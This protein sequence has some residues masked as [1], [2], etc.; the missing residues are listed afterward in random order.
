LPVCLTD[1]DYA[2]AKAGNQ[3][4]IRRNEQE[5]K[6]RN[7]MH[8]R[9]Y[10]LRL[11]KP[12]AVNVTASSDFI[13]GDPIDLKQIKKTRYKLVLCIF[14]DSLTWALLKDNSLKE[15]LP[16]IDKFFS[17][18]TIFDNCYTWGTWTLTSASCIVSG[19]SIKNHGIFH[20]NKN[21][22]LGSSY[23][24]MSEYFQDAGYL[25]FQSC[26]NW[27]KTPAYGY[28]RGYDRTVFK[29]EMGIEETI[30]PLMDHLR[31][32]PERSHFAW[33]S[34]N[35]AHHAMRLTSEISV[36]TRLDIA[37]HD[38]LEKTAKKKRDPIISDP[39]R[40]ARYAEEMKMIDF[41]LGLLFSYVTD[42]YTDDEILVSL[43]SDHGVNYL[44]GE[45]VSLTEGETHTAMM[46]RGGGVPAARADE[47]VQNIDLLPSMLHFSNIAAPASLDGKLPPA[48][49]G[50]DERSFVM[51]EMIYPGNPYQASV[52]S[53]EFDL[54]FT[55]EHATGD[56]GKTDLGNFEFKLFKGGDYSNDVNE[57]HVDTGK[58]LLNYLLAY[59]DKPG[60]E[61]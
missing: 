7:L 17:K 44:T 48:L 6:L 39:P 34:L 22:P 58:E 49:G 11:D 15:T 56:N 25:T 45:A 38:Y 18:G 1:S 36:Q 61:R 16:N 47:L 13:V 4:S 9:F 2:K 24:I 41:N 3:I 42:H 26:G 14:V 12:G 40:S 10:Y 54:Q 53:K 55:S 23:K 33:I 46:I 32:F 31:A 8:D 19:L 27:R 28:V 35:D 50:Q 29:T 30:Y 60:L 5:H 52:K 21:D 51:T 59:H 37:D 20:P 57:E 43:V